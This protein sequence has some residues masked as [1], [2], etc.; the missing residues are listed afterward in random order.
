MDKSKT[1]LA[2]WPSE[3]SETRQ[4]EVEVEVKR[5][6]DFFT[7]VALASALTFQER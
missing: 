5:K 2:G 6:P 7:A 3:T 1:I 4:A